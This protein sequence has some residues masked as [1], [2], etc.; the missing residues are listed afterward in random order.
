LPGLPRSTYD[1]T[2]VN[3]FHR[4]PRGERVGA[5][6]AMKDTEHVEVDYAQDRYAAHPR[7]GGIFNFGGG[8][9]AV[10]YF[11]APC[12]YR[13]KSDV[14]HGFEGY[15][16]RA[17][18]ILTRSLDGGCTWDRSGD[19]VVYDETLPL[20]ERMAFLTQVEREP[21]IPR[22]QIDLNASDT[23]IFFGRTSG[24]QEAPNNYLCFALRSPDRG[25]SWEDVPALIR[26]PEG[27]ELVHKDGHPLVAMPDGTHLAA[28]TCSGHVWLYGT[29]D[30]GLAW[31]PVAHIC[32]DPTG[33]GRPT[34][35]GLILLPSGRLQCYTLNI[36]GLRD[37]IQVNYSDDGGYS[38]SVP[39]PI[40]RWGRSP[41]AAKR[42]PGKTG[43]ALISAKGKHYRS[44]WPMRL[45]D[46][47]IVVLFA[48]RRQPRGMGLIVSEDEGNTWEPERILRED[49]AGEDIGY[50]V[51]VELA[52]GLIFT[53]YYY[54]LDDGNG[55]GGTRFIAGT[56]FRL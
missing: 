39:K 9:I 43:P 1:V 23:A 48:R 42:R 33:L 50:P 49:A 15:K 35:A 34:Y 6:R 12:A 53:A 47:R 7:Q 8:E 37:A 26:P 36:G 56:R 20:E 32:S 45:Q 3:V 25:L 11:R 21:S 54:M 18:A 44:P 41:W 14:T 22:A 38:W 2:G 55:M 28:M 29:D 31:E 27:T 40:V 13:E 17:Q 16:G 46:G 5:L 24:S 52:P 19:V 51:A 10:L 30:H 4:E